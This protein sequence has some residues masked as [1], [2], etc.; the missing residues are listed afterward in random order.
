MIATASPARDHVAERERI[1]AKLLIEHRESVQ[2]HELVGH[3]FDRFA[4]HRQ[5]YV[6]VLDGEKFLGAVSRGQLGFTLS[7]RYGAALHARKPIAN[8]LLPDHLYVGGQTPLRALLELALAPRGSAFH[9]DVAVVDMENNFLGF[10]S[11]QTLV[12]LQSELMAEKRRSVELANRKLSQEVLDRTRAEQALQQEIRERKDA[13]TALRDS[14]EKFRQLAGNITDA[15]W[16]RSPDMREVHYISPAFERIWGRSTK[17]LITNPRQWSD[18]ILPE[19]R[20]RVLAAFATLSGAAPSISIEYRITRPDGEVRWVHV[21]GF[22]VRDDANKLIRL[23]G[24]V[25][26]IT[27]RKGAGEAM[28]ESEERFSSAFEHAPIGV[29]LVSPDGRWLKVNRALCD[30]V[31]Y[32]EAELLTR[33]FQDMTHAEDLKVDLENVR[34]MIAGE[35]RSYQLEKRYIHARGHLVTVLLNVSLV[36]DGRGQPRYFISQIQDITERKRAELEVEQINRR[37]LEFSRRAGMAEMATGVLHNVGNVLNSVNVA[38]SCVADSLKKSKAANLSKV[39]ALLREHESDLGAFLTVDPKGKQL[40]AYLAKLAEHLAEEQ[41]AALRE[42]TQLQKN[43]EHIKEVVTAQQS[44]AKGAGKSETV[45]VTDL[46]EDTLRMDSAEQAHHDIE[47]VKEFEHAP[48]ITVEKHKVLQILMNLVRNAKQACRE[49][50]REEKRLTLRV[51]N[52]DDRVRIAVS[53]NGVGIAPENLARI[54]SHGFTTKKDGH[55]FGLHSAVA[56]AKEMGGEL[57]VHSDGIG[58]GATFTLELPLILLNETT[59]RKPGN[60]SD[61]L[62]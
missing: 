15:F 62:T 9:L 50:G 41:A 28:R 14:D 6:A 4:N 31:G 3:V 26:D 10:I 21:R 52:G 20:E 45:Q 44:C 55:G 58:H 47:V 48:A 22:Q 38:S 42:L 39:V 43:I 61:Y 34:R 51:T 16:I 7:T 13:E 23:T 32:S 60:V 36:R 5:E 56:A 18:A 49:A 8:S 57:R 17:S 35:I 33:T 24:V 40:P 2:A 59:S 30:L 1:P 12:R 25:T 29:A 37:L 27:E 11:V 19:D 53:D 46:L 54:F